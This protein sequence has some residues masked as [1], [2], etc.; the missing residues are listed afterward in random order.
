MRYRAQVIT[1]YG[2]GGSYPFPIDT[3]P[4]PFQRWMIPAI[5]RRRAGLVRY[6][7]TRPPLVLTPASLQS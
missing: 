7:R 5:N 2:V 6:K 1:I 4:L 3:P